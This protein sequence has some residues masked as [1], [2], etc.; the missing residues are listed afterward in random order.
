MTHELYKVHRP[1]AFK[2]VI[3][4]DDTTASLMDMVRKNRVPHCILFTGESGCG[5]TTLARILR[6]KLHCGK[7]DFTELNAASSRGIDDMRNIERRINSAPINGPCRIWLIDE[8]HKLTND[9]QNSILKMLEDTPK[10][11]YFFLCTTSPGKI[12]PT[13]QTRSTIVKV[14]PLTPKSMEELLTKV[15]A[16]E[17]FQITEAV[18]ER[19]T[20]V[21][22][23]SP[24]RALVILNQI[25]GLDTEE[26]Q[27]SAIISNDI[28]RQAFDLCK[29]LIYNPKPQWGEVVAVLKGIEEEPEGL[30]HLVLATA[31]SVMKKGG[32]NCARA[33]NVINCFRD[34]YYECGAAGLWA[35]C[36]EVLNPS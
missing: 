19:I 24:R 34:P 17:S 14:K 28:K 29:V 12:L 18:I 22:N 3:G 13:I 36:W 15:S 25:I 31:V 11:V 8:A 33:Y 9:A 35:S 2:Q 16:K 26:K 30:R 6:D 23:G 27:L 1:T 32:K 20:E 5:K 21:A 4:Q 7:S 10:H